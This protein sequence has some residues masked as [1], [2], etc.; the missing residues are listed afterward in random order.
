[1]FCGQAIFGAALLTTERYRA[2][3]AR[4]FR[5]NPYA[6]LGVNAANELIN[7]G[8]S[9]GMRFALTLAPLSLVQAVSGTTTIFV[10]AFGAALTLF[11]PSLGREDLSPGNLVQK[12]LSAML[13]AGGVY[14][15]NTG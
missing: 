9:L 4:M 1:M 10:F 11:A 15:A 13:V 3:F 7:L 5:T 8:G 6:V 14:L 12:A 2:E